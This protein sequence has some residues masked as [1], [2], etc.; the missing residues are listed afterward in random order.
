MIDATASVCYGTKAEMSGEAVNR[1]LELQNQVVNSKH[2]HVT[3]PLPA[4]TSNLAG[5]CS[6]ASLLVINNFNHT[7]DSDYYWCQILANESLLLPS[8]RGYVS[9]KSEGDRPCR[10]GDFSHYLSPRLCAEYTVS[11]EPI[12]ST[13]TIH[14]LA[15]E[16]TQNEYSE[17]ESNSLRTTLSG[18]T[19]AVRLMTN[20]KD[21]LYGA[22]IGVL[23]LCLII[24]WYRS[25]QKQS[26]LSFTCFIITNIIFIV[27]CA[28]K[29]DK[30]DGVETSPAKE[31]TG[32]ISNPQVIETSLI[33]IY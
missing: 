12:I 16:S 18:T 19:V 2:L 30:V 13:T 14:V 8:L 4:N 5:F 27:E 11:T 10:N 17:P 7:D 20:E 3:V 23:L 26:K 24:M 6:T 28:I 22:T 21:L 15:S 31:T 32:G 25:R 33:C 9:L 1:L 29:A